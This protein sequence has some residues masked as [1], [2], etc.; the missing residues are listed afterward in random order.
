M[1]ISVITAVYN[2]EAT[3]GAAIASVARQTHGD[4]EHVIV[5]GNSKDGSLAAIR[6]A[7]H[8]RMRLISEPDGG[9]YDALNKGIRNATGDVVGFIHSD[10]FLAHD[11]VLEQ[12]AAAFEDPAVEAV[13]SDLDYVSQADTSRVIRHWSTGPFHRERLKRGWMPAHPT[14]YLRREVYEHYGAYDIKFGISADYDFILRYF[15][16]TMQKSVYIPEVLYKM[17]LGGVSNRNLAKIRQ[18]MGE[19]FHAIRR[20]RVG[21]IS[22]LAMKNLSKI[23]QFRT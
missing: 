7:S 8:D 17:R 23:R 10:D 14:L 6:N 4:I 13:F 11:G 5:E 22:T 18:K 12:I 15:S 20:N 2:A 19:D 16:Q 9:I 21:G 3:V 1:K